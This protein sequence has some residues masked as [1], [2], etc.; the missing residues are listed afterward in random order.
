M[1]GDTYPE[2]VAHET[3]IMMR[4]TTVIL[5]NLHTLAEVVDKCAELDWQVNTTFV[6]R[7]NG[8]GSLSIYKNKSHL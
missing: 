5:E 2:I 4:L 6:E 8:G 3:R 1:I 7:F